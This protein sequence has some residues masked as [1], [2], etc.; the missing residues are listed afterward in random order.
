MKPS[1]YFGCLRHY[2]DRPWCS[3]IIFGKLT[4]EGDKVPHFIETYRQIILAEPYE[5]Q[6]GISVS[7]ESN[8][9]HYIGWTRPTQEHIILVDPQDTDSTL[10]Y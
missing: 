10:F 1:H 2:F 4:Q 6:A 8:Q 9:L 3:N 7:A 5:G